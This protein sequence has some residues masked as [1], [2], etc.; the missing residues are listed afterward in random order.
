MLRNIL[1]LL[2]ACAVAGCAVVYKLPTRQ[3]NIM[4]QKDLEQVKVGMTKD[5]VRYLMGTP[6]ASSPFE[7]D[8]WTYFGYYKPP[9]GDA[10]SRTVEMYFQGNKLARVSGDLAQNDPILGTPDFDTLTNESRKDKAD[11]A[12]AKSEKEAG[13]KLPAPTP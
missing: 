11:R 13:V 5:Q 10:V 2:A 3:G 4:D 1:T 9:R 12:R 6:V 8:R 7:P